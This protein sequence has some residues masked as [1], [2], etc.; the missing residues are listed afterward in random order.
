[1]PVVATSVA[2][3]HGGR[4]VLLRVVEGDHET[5]A[6]PLREVV[7]PAR[8]VDEAHRVVVVGEPGQGVR[9]VDRDRGAGEAP[10]APSFRRLRAIAVQRGRRAGGH[11][12]ADRSA[13]R[14]RRDDERTRRAGRIARSDVVRDGCGAR[15]GRVVREHADQ[16]G[17]GRA[18]RIG[19]SAEVARRARR[20]VAGDRRTAVVVGRVHVHHGVAGSGDDRV[21]GRRARHRGWPGGH[22]AA[23]APGTKTQSSTR[24]DPIP[25]ATRPTTPPTR[26]PRPVDFQ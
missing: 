6:V 21:D 20:A 2:D 17:R 5:A 1:M 4:A 12:S 13:R 3:C 15:V 18:R 8:A 26:S 16:H 10:V 24:T 19:G 23:P 11:G 7:T 14:W 22:G 9:A 25:D